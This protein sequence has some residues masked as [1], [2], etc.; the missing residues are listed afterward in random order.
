VDLAHLLIV[1]N[2]KHKKLLLLGFLSMLALTACGDSDDI[3]RD[4]PAISI[5]SHAFGE[6]VTG[7]QNTTLAGTV[8]GDVS[9]LTIGLNDAAIVKVTPVAEDFSIDLTLSPGENTLVIAAHDATGNS[10]TVTFTLYFPFLHLVNDQTASLVIGQNDFD[11]NEPNQGQEGA[12]GN[13][14][15]LVAGNPSRTEGGSL[16]LADTGNNRILG[17]NPIPT[18]NNASANTVIGQVDFIASAGGT[19]PTK[20][21]APRGFVIEDNQYFAVDTGNNRVLIWNTFPNKEEVEAVVALGQTDFASATL[22]CGANKLSAPSSIIVV[23]EKIILSD[24][25]NNRVLIWNAIPTAEAFSIPDIA[26]DRVIGQQHFDFCEPND[27]DGDGISEASP[28]ASTLNG[29]GGIWSDGERLLVADRLNHRVL[30]WNTFPSSNGQA[31]DRVIGQVNMSTAV[32][33]TGQRGLN[34]PK[35]VYSNGNQIFVTDTGNERV[36]IWDAFPVADQ[37]NANRVIGQI[38]FDTK[39]VAQT[40]NKRMI[41]Y[42]SV[43]ADRDHL[44]V[45]DSNRVLVFQEPESP[46]NMALSP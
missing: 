24:S 13:T 12:Q 15:S 29:V 45:V 44:F 25:G 26:P 20:L 14:L 30:V 19:L 34:A 7:S 28:T 33:A 31:A 43:F 18:E 39:D 2:I 16:Y 11:V 4:A 40:S 8:S 27:A 6:E 42:D 35:W 37:E 17:Y 23:N 36:L 10:R 1:Q 21:S 32:P 5:T 41:T 3:D 9:L 46:Q 22:G 38:D